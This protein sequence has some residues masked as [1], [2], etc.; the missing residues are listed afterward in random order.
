VGFLFLKILQRLILPP[1]G[2]LLLMLFGFLLVRSRRNLGRVFITAGFL[3]LYGL[4]INPVASA[5]IAPLER[6]FRPVNLKFVKTGCIVVLGGGTRDRSRLG[7]G[8]EPGEASILI[9]RICLMQ[10]PW[11]EQQWTWVYR[12]RTCSLTISP[13][14]PWR[15]QGQ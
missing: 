15:V 11:H 3:L 13:E 10:M 9:N 2:I 12:K 14:I 1:A 7:L 5:L 8:P 6:D 4:S